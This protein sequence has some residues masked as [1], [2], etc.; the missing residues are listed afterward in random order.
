MY[1]YKESRARQYWWCKYMTG[2]FLFFVTLGSHIKEKLAI[3][4]KWVNSRTQQDYHINR[5]TLQMNEMR[6]M[7]RDGQFSVESYYQKLL[8]RSCRMKWCSCISRFGYQSDQK[9]VLL[10]VLDIKGRK[11][12]ITYVSVGAICIDVQE[13]MQIASYYIVSSY[14]IW[15]KF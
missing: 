10:C 12:K 4:G 6:E 15:W 7:G 3:F 8:M 2:A 13:K 9:S 11:R 14:Y 5:N 1:K